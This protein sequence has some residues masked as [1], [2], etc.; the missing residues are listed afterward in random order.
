MVH[1]DH[2]NPNISSISGTGT[3]KKLS[4]AHYGF[5]E[6]GAGVIQTRPDSDRGS[7]SK[8]FDVSLLK[9]KMSH[10]ETARTVSTNSSSSSG[11]SGTGGANASTGGGGSASKRCGG[12]VGF[13][14]DITSPQ[15]AREEGTTFDT[16]MKEANKFAGTLERSSSLRAGGKGG[17]LREEHLIRLGACGR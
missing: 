8:S 14:L 10:I 6:K 9:S 1:H 4:E 13:N 15:L 3:N 16:C 11:R 5:L 7:G 2:D 12:R 17:L